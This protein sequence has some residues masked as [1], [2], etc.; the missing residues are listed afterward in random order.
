VLHAHPD[1][2]AQ[3]RAGN[4]KLRGFLVGQ[5]M[6]AGKGRTNPQLIHE[7]LDAILAEQP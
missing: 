4:P 6:K 3:V 1:P 5:A 2:A 7:V